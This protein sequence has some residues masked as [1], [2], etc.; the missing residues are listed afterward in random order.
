MT[1]NRMLVRL[2]PQSFREHWGSAL[3]ADAQSAGWRSWPN[4]LA[5]VI[6][7]WLHPVV[8][9]ARSASQRRYRAATMALTITLTI[10]FVGR[11]AVAS[12]S[13]LSGQA[14]RAWNL[15]DCAELMLLGMALVLPLPRLTQ[16][17]MTTL[18]RRVF[19]ALAAPMILGVGAL[20]FADSAAP[21]TMSKSRL[22]VVGCFWLA[23]ALGVI[24]AGRILGTLDTSLVV[25][26]RPARLRLGIA[27][28][29]VA[30]TLASWI[31]L[32]SAVSR[33]G[34]DV[35]SAATGGCLLILTSTFFLTLRDLGR[36]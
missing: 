24:Q 23:L 31:T 30:G 27:I 6:D 13:A 36:C 15:T 10:W 1:V 7:M 3:E 2:Y 35:L 18:L 22:L 34:F 17:A 9:P 12:H 26:P 8:W 11:A 19:Q 21:T 5:A 33:E 4:L 14:H 32:S 29:A 28:L 25:P 20:V 16:H